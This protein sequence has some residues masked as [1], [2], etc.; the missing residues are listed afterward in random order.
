MLLLFPRNRSLFKLY[1][2][3]RCDL[4]V[5]FD[6]QVKRKMTQEDYIRMNR[7]I[8]DSKDLPRE[9]LE[10]IYD[11]IKQKEIALKPTR[12]NMKPTN[13]KGNYVFTNW[14]SKIYCSKNVVK[15]VLENII[16]L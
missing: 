2:L 9:Y 12:G 11:Q 8:N 10:N 15:L 7:G 4:I 13:Y 1:F 3:L 6:A 5:T 16:I 14:T